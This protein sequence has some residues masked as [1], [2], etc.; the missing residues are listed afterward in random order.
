[1]IK[2]C[3]RVLLIDSTFVRDWLGFK[4]FYTLKQAMNRGVFP[5]P[6]VIMPYA[7]DKRRRHPG[8]SHQWR[9]MQG[10]VIDW[11]RDNSGSKGMI[12]VIRGLKE[13]EE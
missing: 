8:I 10:T 5:R 9:W 6:D 4:T 7:R 2:I 11:L 13:E 12:K 1:M 3:K